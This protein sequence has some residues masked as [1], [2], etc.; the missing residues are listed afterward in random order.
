M[1][2]PPGRMIA[3]AAVDDLREQVPRGE[4]GGGDLRRAVRLK[5]EAPGAEVI[6]HP[7]FAKWFVKRPSE[8]GKARKT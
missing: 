1:I 6:R 8:R 3:G 7:S 5:P 4:C 2:R